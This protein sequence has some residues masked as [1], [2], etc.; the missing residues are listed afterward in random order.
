MMHAVRRSALDALKSLAYITV[1]SVE[2]EAK[3]RR[4]TIRLRE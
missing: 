1:A 3:S 2:H 4:A